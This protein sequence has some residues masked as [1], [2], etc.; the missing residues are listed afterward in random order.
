MLRQCYLP[1][2]YRSTAANLRASRFSTSSVLSANR[3][4]V[5]TENGNPADVLKIQSYDPLPPPPAGSLNIRFRLAPI[6]PSDINLIQGVYPVKPAQLQFSG[7]DV[8]V[9]GNEGVAEV[10]DIGDGVN[11][12][13]EGDRVVVAKPQFGTWS[14]SRVLR[15]EDVIKLPSIGLSEVNAAVITVRMNAARLSHIHMFLIFLESGKSANCLQHAAQFCQAQRGRLG[16]AKRQVSLMVFVSY[17][18]LTPVCSHQERTALCVQ[19]YRRTSL[20]AY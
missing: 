17:R 10:V 19:S 13:Q 5:Y 6:N 8:F 7:Q 18:P 2:V 1:R 4:V 11:G 3:A 9:A 16:I 12:I 15:S 20:P 14:S